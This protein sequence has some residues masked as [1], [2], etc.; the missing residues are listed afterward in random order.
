FRRVLFR[1]AEDHDAVAAA[2][3]GG[4]D[5]KI[6]LALQDALQ[7][8]CLPVRLDHAD[9]ARHGDSGRLRQRL[10]AQ[11]V[12]HQRVARAGVMDLDIAGIA[13]VHADD[14]LLPQSSERVHLASSLANSWLRKRHSSLSRYPV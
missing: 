14:A 7:L 2:A 13:L 8:A 12:I 3:I 4:L 9:Q 6:G 5:D 1:S 11:L 10:A